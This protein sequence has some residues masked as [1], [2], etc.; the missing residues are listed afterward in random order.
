MNGQIQTETA[1]P[2]I[3]LSCLEASYICVGDREVNLQS[4]YQALDIC[5]PMDVVLVTQLAGVSLLEH[6]TIRIL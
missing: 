6:D 3:L 1:R 4:P 5:V 2:D